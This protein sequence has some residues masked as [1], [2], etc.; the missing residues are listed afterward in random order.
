M[1]AEDSAH[2]G[3]WGCASGMAVGYVWDRRLRGW[4]W[5]W[6]VT[7]CLPA[8][9]GVPL[10]LTWVYGTVVLSLCRSRGGCR[11]GRTPGDV[12]VVELDNLAK[13]ESHTAG[14]PWPVPSLLQ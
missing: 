12:G 11:G 7:A 6:A 8:G 14:G 10:V 4:G 9:V 13:R 1:S 3:E 5:G 2:A